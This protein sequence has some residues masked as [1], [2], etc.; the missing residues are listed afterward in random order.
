MKAS[1]MVSSPANGRAIRSG[2]WLKLKQFIS[3]V[4]RATALMSVWNLSKFMYAT[5]AG[6]FCLHQVIEECKMK[7]NRAA[8]CTHGPLQRPTSF[9]TKVHDDTMLPPGIPTAVT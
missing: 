7:V 8:A 3:P 5:S 2:K 1:T 6:S 4:A 9:P